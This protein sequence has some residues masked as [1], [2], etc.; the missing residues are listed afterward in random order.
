MCFLSR[1]SSPA[2]FPGARLTICQRKSWFDFFVAASPFL[3][4]YPFILGV[5]LHAIMFE[6]RGIRRNKRHVFR[7]AAK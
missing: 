5:S 4:A 3:L 1:E 6:R 7:P 2:A